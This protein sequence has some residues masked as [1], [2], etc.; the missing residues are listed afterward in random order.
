MV[1]A[2]PRV[3][4][5]RVRVAA[6]TMPVVIG[7]ERSARARSP[8]RAAAR[9]SSLLAAEPA[10][11]APRL[12]SSEQR[13]RKSAPT[14]DAHVGCPALVRLGARARARPAARAPRGGAPEEEGKGEEGMRGAEE[15]EH[16][17]V[18]LDVVGVHAKH[19]EEDARLDR[20]RHDAGRVDHHD[21]LLEL[22]GKQRLKAV[23]EEGRRLAELQ[24]RRGL[25]Q[26]DQ[27]A[28]HE[29]QQ[30]HQD[31]RRKVCRA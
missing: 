18:A 4:P 24:W 15:H 12:A 30:Q 23:A 26:V 17:L 31:G 20:D 28:V 21:R 16:A 13:G 29:Q 14:G 1:S 10:R 22:V 8:R 5:R 6:K 27:R 9:A 2:L 7:A 25:A 19:G 11:R 3:Q